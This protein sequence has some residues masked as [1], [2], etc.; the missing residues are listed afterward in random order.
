M[1][2]HV[3]QLTIHSL[4]YFCSRAPLG[5]GGEGWS[6]PIAALFAATWMKSKGG[7]TLLM[8]WLRGGIVYF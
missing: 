7:V 6:T 1:G 2:R 4:T 8:K 5:G 3:G